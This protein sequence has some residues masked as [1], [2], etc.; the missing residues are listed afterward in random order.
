VA[1]YVVAQRL[2]RRTFLAAIGAAAA[3]PVLAACQSAPPSTPQVVERV[4]T[5]VVEK[6][7][8]RVVT[9]VVEK[10]VTQVVEKQ[11]TQIVEKQVDK[12]ITY[13][14][15]SI[16]P[17]EAATMGAG[18]GVKGKSAVMWGLKYDP[19]AE[20]YE[21]LAKDFN[22][23]TGANI[24]VS[25]QPWPI[26][27]KVIAAMAAG[28]APD[29]GCIMGKV[30]LPLVMRNAVLD[31]G[32]YYK[33][34]GV[35]TLPNKDF[36]QDSIQCYTYSGK[37]YGV[38]TET[39]TVGWVVNVPVDQVEKVGLKDTYP[40]TS[41]KLG[42]DS[43]EQMWE[44]AKAL[45]V[46]EAGKVKKWG[47]SSKGWDVCT[48]TGLMHDQGVNFWDNENKK[49]QFSTDAGIKAF[50]LHAET[51]VKMGIETE[52]DQNHVDAALAGKVA[53]AKGNGTP[54]VEGNKLGYKYELA[55]SPPS[56]AGK[57]PKYG[58]E[59]GWGFVGL[60]QGKNRDVT[61]E[62]LKYM[63]TKRGQHV[64]AQ[65]YG[66]KQIAFIPLKDDYSYYVNPDN[67]IVAKKFKDLPVLENTIYYGEG[68][69]Y[70]S[71]LEK[72]VNTTSS[73]I[74]SKKLNS[75]QAA[76]QVQERMEASYKQFQ[77]D[78]EKMKS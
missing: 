70:I 69:G 29:T 27:T 4:V 76:K 59:G 50:Q 25:P 72:H 11:V 26:E 46:E 57:F 3:A 6:P 52:L 40:P 36:Y 78:V 43:Y 34:M 18:K 10:Q 56:A 2:G 31:L 51:P 53:L 8:D 75:E 33:D 44:L 35:S 47:L 16:Y 63:L 19:H 71:E 38:P 30:L 28:T 61:A 32:P 5:Q 45:Q 66:G 41:G 12:V 73:D 55:V 1:K 20:T 74:R 24:T 77:A 58:G 65:I 68:F 13:S 14:V 17:P 23:I 9:Q 60:S 42:F 49:F 39:G 22:E 64:W 21:R 67:A 62:F 54:W 7:V 15:W 48:I 37:I